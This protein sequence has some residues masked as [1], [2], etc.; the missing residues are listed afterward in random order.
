MFLIFIAVN[1]IFL[2]FFFRIGFSLWVY[3]LLFI[4]SIIFVLSFFTEEWQRT[5]KGFLKSF[6]LNY[7]AYINLVVVIT[8]IYFIL[9]YIL[10]TH[11]Q[12]NQPTQDLFASFIIIGLLIVFLMLWILIK[13]LTWVKTSYFWLFLVR[14]YIA[15]QVPH[16]DIF[17]YFI[18]FLLATTTVAH[19][20]YLIRFGKICTWFVYIILISLLIILF[21]ILHKFLIKNI[22]LLTLVIQFIIMSI[23]IFMIYIQ[24]L[25]SKIIQIEKKLEQRQYE[26]NLFWYSDINLTEKEQNF[27][28]KHKSKKKLYQQVIDFLINAPWPIKVIFALTNTIPVILASWYFFQNL[29]KWWNIHNEAIYWLNTVIF[30]INFI[31]FKK[32]NRFVYI[33]RLFAFFVVNFITYFTIIDFFWKNF[34]YIAIWGIIWNLLSTSLILII[35]NKK[36]IF[37]HF[38]YLVWSVINF[39]WVFV[40][41]YFLFKIQIAY[42][43]KLWV[44]MLYLGL[45]LFLYRIIY[46]K[47]W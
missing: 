30:F 25:Y 14:L 29:W 7:L 40:N 2:Y 21:I 3:F 41:I 47:I 32:L 11:S 22:N 16:I 26:I 1:L 13:N 10:E 44:I 27:Y 15:V 12:I 46:K 35:W 9:K 36:N 4:L 20:I 5:W 8:W 42:S 45:Y 24:S 33:Q 19:L 38:D 37:D 43:L 6:F 23:L 34:T 39:L 18:S 31:L 28:N 17:Y